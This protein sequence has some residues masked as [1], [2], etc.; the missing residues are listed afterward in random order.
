MPTITPLLRFLRSMTKEQREAFAEKC[1]TTVVYLYQLAGHAEP[2]PQLQLA[3]RI[4]KESG[5]VHKKLMTEALT[6]EDLLVGKNP[7]DDVEV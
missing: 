7:D 6:Y 2:N 3:V 1:G 4:V 5:R